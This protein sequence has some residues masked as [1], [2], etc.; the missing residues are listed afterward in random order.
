M[1]PQ[2]PY[3][4][5]PNASMQTDHVPLDD[6]SGAAAYSERL[7]APLSWWIAAAG[8]AAVVWW[9]FVFAVPMAFAVALGLL[10]LIA[11]FAAVWTYGA[12][13]VGVADGFV[14]AGSAQVETEFCGEVTA[15]DPAQTAAVS[16]RDA[17]ARAFRAL[18]PYVATAVRIQIRDER[19]PTPYWL[20]STRHP[21]QLAEAIATAREVQD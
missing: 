6:R 1:Q 4:D 5:A 21:E 15:L 11:A 19:D 10:T 13:L 9:A 20:I 17:D 12:L 3:R 7:R 18:R 2:R 16:G 8:L 14:V